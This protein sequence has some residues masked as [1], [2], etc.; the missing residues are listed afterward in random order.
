M[1]SSLPKVLHAVAG[2]PMI[3]HVV[4]ALAGL[5]PSPSP[6]AVVVAPDD[7]A[8][9]DAVRSA[10]PDLDAAFP[11]QDVPRG[12]GDAALRAEG[13]VA[14]RAATVLL[15]CGD[16][17]LLRSADFAALLARHD[18]AGAAITLLT[19]TPA[20][21]TGY[22]R[23][24]R[25]PAG[26]VVAIVEEADATAAERAIA[27]VNTGAYAVRD[28]WLWPTLAALA[29]S[30]SGE[31][32]LTDLV[33]HA[34]ADGLPVAALRLP[35]AEAGLGINTRAGLS[36]AEAA[37]RDRVRRRH[38]DEGVTLIDP[39]TTWIDADAVI[40][41]DTVVWPGSYL[42]GATVVGRGCRIGPNAILRDARLG[43]GAVVTSSVVEDA[44]VGAGSDV[45][46]FAHLRAGTRLAPGVH[47]G[48]FAEIKNSALAAGVRVGH[49]SYL[50]DAAVGAG[51]NIGAG[52]VTCNFDGRD[53][54]RT[55]VG[56]GAFIG[57]D[58]M[59]VAPVRVGERARTGA[60]SVVTR[61]VPDGATVAGVP[62][63]PLG[64]AGGDAP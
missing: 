16:A 11:I 5:E 61:D 7:A 2:R 64:A 12:T 18:E 1:R 51:A 43:D 48:N 14:G 32:Y 23:V 52:T 35:D 9:R 37:M 60:G 42:L 50:G 6:L 34:I 22:G 28:A 31:V 40:G 33:A 49:F 26:A 59:L 19:A 41:A 53:K 62:A 55:T 38:L 4:E 13:A 36:R 57:S 63:R 15:A 27:E 45:G 3:L 8:V 44:E 25:D 56:A 10:R 24:V 58:T 29:P 39:P 46:P 47:V 21:A 20:D 54:H 17:P 30:P